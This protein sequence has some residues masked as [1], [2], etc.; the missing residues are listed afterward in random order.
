MKFCPVCRIFSIPDNAE[1][2]VT[3]KR[4]RIKDVEND[5]LPGL[6]KMTEEQWRMFAATVE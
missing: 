2:C 1:T 5:T 4:V 3:C 6:D